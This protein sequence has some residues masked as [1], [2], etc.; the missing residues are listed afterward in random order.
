MPTEPTDEELMRQFCAGDDQAYERLYARW[1]SRVLN[2]LGRRTGSRQT[3]E[4]ALQETF[5]NVYRYRA[6][7]RHGRRFSPW[8]FSIAANAGKDA[9][10]PVPDALAYNGPHRDR[11][12][13][14]DR[15][16]RALRLLEPEERRLLLLSVEGFS[17][18]EV[19]EM[20][21]LSPGAV[22]MRVSRARAHV[23]EV[24]GG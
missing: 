21:G 10:E 23:R 24:L 6:S 18:A 11:P 19:G 22:R 17:S 14:R 16:L 13:V 20:V 12:E 15:L 9:P 4:D 1:S 5:L 3:A 8:L 2:F 7:F